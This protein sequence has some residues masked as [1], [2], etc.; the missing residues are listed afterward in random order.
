MICLWGAGMKAEVSSIPFALLCSALYQCALRQCEALY[1]IF[2]KRASLA[3]T[4]LVQLLHQSWSSVPIIIFLSCAGN[5][6][7]TFP[8]AIAATQIAW[9]MIAAPGAFASSPS[10][11]A[12][13][14]SLQWG[15]DYLMACRPTS[16][17][18]VAQVSLS[19][20]SRALGCNVKRALNV[21]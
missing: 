14:S 7:L 2:V 1:Q 6:K 20:M 11:S 19:H 8:T 17:D 4:C 9:A 16:W 13:L 15:T 10:T 21:T 3:D 12:H 18:F 5:L